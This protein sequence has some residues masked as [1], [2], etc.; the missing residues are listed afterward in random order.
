MATITLRER[1][2]VFKRL[3]PSENLFVSGS[4]LPGTYTIEG[5][6]VFLNGADTAEMAVAVNLGPPQCRCWLTIESIGMSPERFNVL[7]V[8]MI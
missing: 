3:K 2:P 1:V 8:P 5:K 4:A 7:D 6:A